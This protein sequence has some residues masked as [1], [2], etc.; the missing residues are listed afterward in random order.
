MGYVGGR[1]TRVDRATIDSR[2]RA[3]GKLRGF[4]YRRS[5]DA[6]TIPLGQAR[7]NRPC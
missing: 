3:I 6:Q 2:R 1:F 7:G 4:T 5:W